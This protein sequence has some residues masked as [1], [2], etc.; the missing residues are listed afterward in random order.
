MSDSVKVEYLYPPNMLDGGWD[1]KQGNKR[2]IVQ[3]SGLSDSTG[4]TDVVKIKMSDLKTHNGNVPGR[5]AVEWIEYDIFG[6]TCVL[7]WDR[8]PHAEIIRLNAHAVNTAWRFDWT[9]FGGKVDPGGDD[10]TGDILLTTTNTDSADSYEIT[11][12][13]RLKD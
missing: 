1:E 3:L 4:E 10:R 8:A 11:I 2:V 13:L 12:C 7:E 5:T 6:L 9:S